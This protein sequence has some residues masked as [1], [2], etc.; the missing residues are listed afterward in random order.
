MTEIIRYLKHRRDTSANW[1]SN[2]PTPKAGQICFTT[3]VLYTGTD[4]MKFKVGDGTQTWAQL[5]Y[6]PIGTASTPTLQQVLT[7]GSV[8]TGNNTITGA[9]TLNLGSSGSQLVNLNSQV[10]NSNYFVAGDQNVAYSEIYGNANSSYLSTSSDGGNTY[11]QLSLY[12]SGQSISGNGSNNVIIIDDSISNKGLIAVAD[13]QVN[14]T[15][16]SYVQKKYITD[17]LGATNGIATLDATTKI[18]LSQIPASLIGSANYQGT[19]NANTNTP[20]LASGTGTK[21]HY[22]V[23]SVAGSTNLD[24]VTDWKLG[25]WAIYNGT[26]W[27]KVDN[28]D[29]VISVNGNIGAVALTGTANRITISGAN[30]FDIGSDVVTLGGTQTLTNKSGNISQ[31]TND[32]GYS[33]GNF[34]HRFHGASTT[35]GASSTYYYAGTNNAVPLNSSSRFVSAGMTATSVDFS[36][37]CYVT[38]TLASAHN[39]IVRLRNVTT[40][41]NYDFTTTFQLTAAAQNLSGSLAFVCTQGDNLEIQVITPA[42]T[43]TPTGCLFSCEVNLKR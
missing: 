22:Y 42:F 1:T 12:N 8:L 13:Y 16:Y 43:T 6:M 19:W 21:G 17:M 38:G 11:A 5:D 31:W 4:Q 28:T 9:F 25:D 29:A 24:G 35:L 40:A 41:T 34:T 30:V 33:K 37:A 36:I 2:N 27:E 3:D 14:Y 10:S 39:V 18:P 20:S 26:A 7:S 15:P 23:V 32:S